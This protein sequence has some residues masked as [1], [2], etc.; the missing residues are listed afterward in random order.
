MDKSKNVWQWA[1]NDEMTFLLRRICY[2]LFLSIRGCDP[3]VWTGIANPHLYTIG[4][5]IRWNEQYV[6]LVFCLIQKLSTQ[7][8]AVICRICVICVP[9]PHICQKTRKWV[10]RVREENAEMLNLLIINRMQILKITSKN[11]RKKDLSVSWVLLKSFR[12]NT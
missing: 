1:M 7:N 9:L 11:T 8:Y 6:L 2:S 3:R 4:W 10:F 12:S 5:Y